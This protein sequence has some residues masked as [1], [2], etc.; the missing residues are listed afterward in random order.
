[1]LTRAFPPHPQLPESS[2][3]EQQ[4]WELQAE[5]WPGLSRDQDERASSQASRLRVPRRSQLDMMKA[6]GWYCFTNQDR[7][8]WLWASSTTSIW[9]LQPSLPD[10]MVSPLQNAQGTASEWQLTEAQTAP[11]LLCSVAT[12]LLVGLSSQSA[13]KKEDPGWFPQRCSEGLLQPL[14]CWWVQKDSVDEG[15]N[16]PEDRGQAQSRGTGSTARLWHVHTRGTFLY[17]LGGPQTSALRGVTSAMGKQN[18]GALEASSSK[19]KRSVFWGK[20][21]SWPRK[22]KGGGGGGIHS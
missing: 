1:M 6:G 4:Q 17:M 9:S 20:G 10:L 5:P 16:S 19:K 7:K 22:G 21:E 14:A 13:T 11:P 15:Y 8:G 2:F 12:K 18:A 3:K